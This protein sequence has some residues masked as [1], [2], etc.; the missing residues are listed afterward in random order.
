MP[1]NNYSR[2]MFKIDY[3][4]IHNFPELLK[5]VPWRY[6]PDTPHVQYWYAES[7]HYILKFPNGTYAF[8]MAKSP[9]E[10]YEKF[11]K[12]SK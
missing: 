4:Q 8:V 11:V 10:A 12:E 9:V 2:V 1:K 5:G 7:E 3:S 6:V